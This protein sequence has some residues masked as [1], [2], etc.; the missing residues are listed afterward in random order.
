MMMI[1]RVLRSVRHLRDLRRDDRGAV[2][3]IFAAMVPAVLGGLA[4]A[5]DLSMYR[6]A[7][8]RL[9]AA[10]DSAALAGLQALAKGGNASARAI[11]IAMDNVPAEYG[12]I[13]T[14]NDIQV[15]IYST[16]TGFVPGAG[17]NAN[18]VRVVTARNTARGNA[19]PQIF[20]ILFTSER[21]NISAQVIA[22]RPLN[23]FY[24]PPEL[25]NLDNEAGDYNELYVYCFD[26]TGTSPV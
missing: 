20:S 1:D 13:L 8:S 14:A 10:A 24:E 2:A 23:V 7:Q 26:S 9:Q 21:A 18:A 15:G 12:D 5:V 4:F 16:D 22:A 25:T 17:P 3:F 6:I 11:E 19:V